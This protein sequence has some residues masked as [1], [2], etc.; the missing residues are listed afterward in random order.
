MITKRIA[1]G[2]LGVIVCSV[3][4]WWGAA[5]QDKVEQVFRRFERPAGRLADA[6]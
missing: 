6:P 3:V 1:V 4:L 5:R 2:L